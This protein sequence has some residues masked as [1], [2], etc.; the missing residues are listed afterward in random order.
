MDPIHPHSL[1][2][3][4]APFWFVEFFKVLGFCLHLVPMNLW[5]AGV[6]LAMLFAWKGGEQP[7]RWSA[8]LMRQMPLLVAFGV[9]F[10]I[11]PLLFTQ[12]AYYWAFYPA[13]ILMAWSW[14]AIVLLLIPAYYGVY[15]YVFGLKE[16]VMPRWRLAAGWTAAV[17]LVVIGFLFANGFSLMGNVRAWQGL[18]LGTSV[19]G[20]P[21]GTAL[22]VADPSLWP[23]W[24]LLFGLALVTTSAWTAVD[25]AWLAA[26]ESDAYRRWAQQFAWRLALAGVVWFAAAGSWY[27]WF[28]WSKDVSNTMLSGPAIVLTVLTAVSPGLPLALLFLARNRRPDRIW[29]ACVGGAQLGA[30]VL[31][32]VSRQVVQNVELSPLLK[33][34]SQ[35]EAVQWS[36][37]VAFLVVFVA[38]AAVVAWMIA[39]VWYLSPDT[40]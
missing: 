14:F 18:W 38:G 20:A 26:R 16:P 8:R 13:T 19:A 3:M 35:G 2:G 11:V 36:P 6:I 15:A 31:N 1:P 33:P 25:A 5:Y 23:R 4:P 22:N 21:T 30:L 12:V 10:G 40:R 34:W 39:Q 24:L 17:L 32:A 29:A 9:N 28:T 27:V 7:R 37:L